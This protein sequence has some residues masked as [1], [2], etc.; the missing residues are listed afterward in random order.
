MK[1]QKNNSG[2]VLLMALSQLLL[3]VFVFQW[4]HSRYSEERISLRKELNRSFESARQ[5]ML[6]STV[7]KK[8]IN[9]LLRQGDSVKIS[10]DLSSSSDDEKHSGAHQTDQQLRKI[11]RVEHG[12]K[13]IF[14]SDDSLTLPVSG[15]PGKNTLPGDAD[16]LLREIKLV[17]NEAMHRKTLAEGGKNVLGSLEADTALVQRLTE[18][19]L[20]AG[21]YAFT[22]S[23]TNSKNQDS[24]SAGMY[25][26]S[27]FFKQPYG[28][29]VSGTRPFLFSKLVP[30]ILLAVFLLLVTLLAFIV[31]Y[32]SIRKQSKLNLLKDEF[33][34]NISH[35]LKTPVATV[36]LSL[37]ALQ[38]FET[39]RT[40][41]VMQEY[42]RMASQETSRLEGLISR[43]MDASMLESGALPL[44]KEPVDLKKLSEEVVASLH[45]RLQAQ[46]A[47]V[48]T[49]IENDGTVALADAIHLRS[50]LVNLL[51]NSLKYREVGNRISI[52]ISGS[53]AHVILK[54]CDNGPGI[55]EQYLSKV[56]ER[57]FRVPAKEGHWVKGH[58]LGLNYVRQIMEQSGGSISL[59]NLREGGLCAE[60]TFLAP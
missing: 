50:V 53:D 47:E 39:L 17:I 34:S 5:E 54:L 11:I 16:L 29:T 12:Q 7:Q 26:E 27:H 18:N 45:L 36:K 30:E 44:L 59:K 20:R 46:Q 52:R 42:L 19:R 57:F 14:Y 41:E 58:G 22:Y 13:M 6:D 15:K 10:V 49:I 25:F 48:N 4:L 28:L 32:L 35:E 56:F 9:P 37:E 60:L 2:V 55:P 8:L 43:V 23:W 24:S 38:Q 51:D 31:S 33:I 21:G 3:A 40:P 1:K